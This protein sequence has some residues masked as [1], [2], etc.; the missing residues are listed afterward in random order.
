MEYRGL[1][2]ERIGLTGTTGSR[3]CAPAQNFNEGTAETMICSQRQCWQ[4]GSVVC[5]FCIF[6]LPDPIF[7]SYL[8]R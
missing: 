8:S 3:H 2:Q 4:S 1:D 7:L 5:E 6:L